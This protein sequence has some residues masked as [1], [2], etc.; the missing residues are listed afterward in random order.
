[1]KIN[2]EFHT[3]NAAFEENL[4]L[5]IR[6]VLER[7]SNIVASIVTSDNCRHSV[8][9]YDSNGNAVGTVTGDMV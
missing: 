3:D 4:T 1:M 5:E 9:L 7:A 8:K 6:E 2:I